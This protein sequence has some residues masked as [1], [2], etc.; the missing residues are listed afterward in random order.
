MGVRVKEMGKQSGS[1]SHIL[2]KSQ[3][4][5][6]QSERVVAL[7]VRKA[8]KSHSTSFRVKKPTIRFYATIVGGRLLILGFTA[9]PALGGI[10]AGIDALFLARR[11]ANNYKTH[12]AHS[13]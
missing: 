3:C 9:S 2:A 7:P 12:H 11:E 6:A 13:H 8:R 1:F 5:I 4:P 10:A